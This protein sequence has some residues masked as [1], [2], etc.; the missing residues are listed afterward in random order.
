ME[1]GQL[2]LQLAFA[3]AGPLGEDVEDELR[4]VDDLHADH[5]LQFAELRRRE[6]VVDDDHVDARF[7]AGERQG[8]RF[9][10]ADEGG[11]VGGGPFLQRAHDHGRTGGIREC[12]EFVERLFRV[13]PAHR[14]GDEADECRAL[15]C[16]EPSFGHGRLDPARV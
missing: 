13:G 3:R 16:G 15:D 11:R 14:A 10:L 6:L 7:G 9:A 8:L 1:L 12:G 4:A 2:H 5:L